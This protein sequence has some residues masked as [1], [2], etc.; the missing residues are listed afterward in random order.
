MLR[1]VDHTFLFLF[2]FSWIPP[3]PFLLSLPQHWCNR[4]PQLAAACSTLTIQH[5]HCILQHHWWEKRTYVDFGSVWHPYYCF[6]NYFWGAL[7]SHTGV[8]WAS[9]MGTSHPR[10]RLCP[11]DT[12]WSPDSIKA[13]IWVSGNL[14]EEGLS[15]NHRVKV[16]PEELVRNS[17]KPSCTAGIM[18]TG[19]EKI[20]WG[21]HG[22]DAKTVR[23]KKGLQDQAQHQQCRYNG[24]QNRSI[25]WHPV[26]RCQ[27]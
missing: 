20:N 22:K 23:A 15:K 12:S 14:S 5:W 9:S 7:P 17:W 16:D 10:N 25:W 21:H 2:S 1:P 27:P 19:L 11:G 8:G 6:N 4:N 13:Q 3:K 24:C 18:E 26:Q